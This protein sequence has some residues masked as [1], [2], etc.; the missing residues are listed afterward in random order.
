MMSVSLSFLKVA[1]KKL[2][3]NE[4]PTIE[5]LGKRKKKM[6]DKVTAFIKKS[7]H[8]SRVPISCPDIVKAIYQQFKIDIGC[9]TIQSYLKKALSMSYCRLRQFNKREMALAAR[10]QR[11]IAAYNYI[12]NLFQ[13]KLIINIDESILS[14]TIN[15]TKG[16]LKYNQKQMFTC[17]RRLVQIN[18]T[19]ACASDG[20]L[21]FA[22]NKGINSQQHFLLFLMK[23]I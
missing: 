17:N 22:I 21:Y 5:R 12:E 6:N 3:R 20:N 23:L 18:M 2:K 19:A 4:E 13:N 1:W 8:N 15:K 11:Q 14:N 16:W 7:I 10:L 9:R